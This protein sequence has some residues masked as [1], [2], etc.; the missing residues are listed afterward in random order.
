M[1]ACTHTQTRTGH[2]HVCPP[3]F[4]HPTHKVHTHISPPLYAL[5]C[6]F[7]HTC[8]HANVDTHLAS[9][10]HTHTHTRTHKNTHVH[11]K[12]AHTPVMLPLPHHASTECVLCGGREGPQSFNENHQPNIVTPSRA[13]KALCPGKAFY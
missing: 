10:T 13:E 4:T 11:T 8:R 3:K 7:K 12:H 1:Y 2:P 9:H 6:T 5:I